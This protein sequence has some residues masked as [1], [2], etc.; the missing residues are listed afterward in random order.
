MTKITKTKQR[1]LAE[2][3]HRLHH[4]EEIFV[5]PYV[6]NGGSAKIFEKQG[7]KAISTTSAGIAYSMGYSDG[8]NLPFEDLVRITREVVRTVDIPVS[9]DMELGYGE[10][11][12]EIVENVRSIVEAGAVGI[13]IEDGYNL[14]NPYLEDLGL[15]VAK[16]EA[17]SKLREEM[18]IPFFINART[19]VFWLEIGPSEERIK[20]AVK[21]GNAFKAAGADCIFIPGGLTKEEVKILVEEINSPVNIII[22]PVFNDLNELSKLGVKRVCM[23]SGASRASMERVIHIAREL[24]EKNSMETILQCK[25]SYSN[26]NNFFK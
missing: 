25:F 16:I 1:E 17:L 5:L 8:E 14:D 9:V 20:E 6:W 3:F 18:G 23:G 21:R 12:T 4:Q 24:Y 22:N 2:T 15:Q 26:A 13:N 7:F 19:C 11:I 10:S